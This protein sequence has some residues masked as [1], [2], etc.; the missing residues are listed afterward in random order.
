MIILQTRPRGF[1]AAERCTVRTRRR[2]GPRVG[3]LSPIG[4]PILTP[5]TS[6]RVCTSY[7]RRWMRLICLTC[8]TSPS[9]LRVS[10]PLPMRLR[11]LL[12]GACPR[13]AQLTWRK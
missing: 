10:I 3:V 2:G 4:R 7:C 6:V 1:V 8:R 13:G 12:N 9:E 5:R 11:K